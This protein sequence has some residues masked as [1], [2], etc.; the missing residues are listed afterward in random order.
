MW[1]SLRATENEEVGAMDIAE[2]RVSTH[3]SP[4]DLLYEPQI[5]ALGESSHDEQLLIRQDVIPFTRTVD[6]TS[7]YSSR[8]LDLTLSLGLIILLLPA[9]LAVSVA[10]WL[11]DRG[12]LIFAH[13][14]VGRNGRE[15]R[16]FKFRTMRLDAEETLSMLL[17]RDSA[18]R[19]EWERTQKLLEDPRVTPVGQ[20][21]RNTCLDELPQLFNVLLGDMAL[22]GPRPIVKEE[23]MR[24]GKYAEKYLSVRPGLT[25]LWQVTRS[26]DT[27]YRRRV[28]TD[29]L[30]VRERS[31][32][33]DCRILL[34]TIPAVLFSR[35]AC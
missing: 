29:A 30:Y 28:A 12:P 35:G 11:F 8:V 21:L 33:L 3:D 19:H 25:G 16:C 5:T 20:F 9:M 7:Q 6:A 34:A 4:E 17:A 22:V 14:R 1:E 10:I 24:Y 15:F 18:L 26:E 27:S 13:S 32:L 2:R 23:L 31:F